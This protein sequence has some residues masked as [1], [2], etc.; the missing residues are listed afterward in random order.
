MK[1]K[2]IL[3]IIFA[4]SV[5]AQAQEPQA[6]EKPDERQQSVTNDDRGRAFIIRGEAQPNSGLGNHGKAT[7]SQP[8][9]YSIFLGSDWAKPALRVREPELANLLAN[10]RDQAQL[11]ALDESGIK[12]RFGAT[13]SQE[14][15]D[16]AA[17]NRSISDLEIQTVLAGMLK[18]GS[19]QP[20]N[21]NTIYVVF[22][23]PGLHS[24]LGSMIA[25]K[26]YIA[27]HNFFNASGARL[28]YVVIPFEEDRRMAESNAARAF[29][30]A[31]FDTSRGGQ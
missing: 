14:Q 19:L 2:A 18:E 25:G 8:E 29:L 30:A 10:V 28:H 5:S 11:N 9:Q 21:A 12:N 13:L 15:L 1:L 4:L 7:M 31:V 22:L 3:L 27:Y 16:A 20:P 26:H 17:G 24:T 6:P 23:D